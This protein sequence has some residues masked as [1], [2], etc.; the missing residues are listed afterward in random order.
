MRRTRLFMTFPIRDLFLWF[1]LLS[2]CHRLSATCDNVLTKCSSDFANLKTSDYNCGGIKR[3]YYGDGS[4]YFTGG[5]FAA[6][7]CCCCD[8]T[9]VDSTKQKMR[10]LLDAKINSLGSFSSTAKNLVSDCYD[11]PL[12]VEA[13][14]CPSSCSTSPVCE[15]LDK[16]WCFVFLI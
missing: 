4:T 11:D 8:T 1:I 7:P 13:C 6:D 9:F 12:Q 14:L 2:Q 16:S 3:V 10:A 5:C 15:F